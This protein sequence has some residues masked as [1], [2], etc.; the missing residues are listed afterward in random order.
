MDE[1]DDEAHGKQARAVTGGDVPAP[2]VQARTFFT[3]SLFDV[4]GGQPLDEHDD[5]AHGKRGDCKPGP[6]SRFV[7][8]VH[9]GQPHLSP[10]FF[11]FWLR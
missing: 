3:I 6:S 5:E 9:G 4:H 2:G 10:L 7:F 1:H 11:S 8:G